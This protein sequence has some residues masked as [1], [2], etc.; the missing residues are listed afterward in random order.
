MQIRIKHYDQLTRDELY[1]IL[2][3]RAVVFN[4]GQQCPC[5][6]P[7]GLDR[8]AWHLCL[9]N[10][11]GRLT[12][13]ARLF[14][15]G[16]Y[17]PGYTAIGRVAVLEEHRGRGLGKRIMHEALDFLRKR[18][19]DVPVVISAQAYLQSFYEDLGFRSTSDEYLEE[20][21]PHIRMEF[22]HHDKNLML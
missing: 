11:A 16:D 21:I 1:E 19:P 15:P 20:G 13:Y 5:V 14:G 6:D 8:L 2:H 3:L 7:D 18:F 9:R 10:D 12:G 4:L 17:K 22:R